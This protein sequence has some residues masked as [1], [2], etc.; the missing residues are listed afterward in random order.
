[1]MS[2][3]LGCGLT[4]EVNVT[5]FIMGGIVRAA[6]HRRNFGVTIGKRQTAGATVVVTW[7]IRVPL[8]QIS[9]LPV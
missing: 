2:R 1:M 3:L 7:K 4:P 6:F 9:K 5:F 8:C